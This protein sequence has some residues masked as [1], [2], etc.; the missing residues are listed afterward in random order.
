MNW[1]RGSKGNHW[2][3]CGCL[4]WNCDLIEQEL[5]PQGIDIDGHRP[6]R[7]RC[8]WWWSSLSR[9]SRS[10]KHAF[11]EGSPG[12]QVARR[13]GVI[14]A[15]LRAPHSAVKQIMS[16]AAT[17][18]ERSAVT[19]RL[20]CGIN[21]VSSCKITALWQQQLQLF[22]AC[23]ASKYI[24]HTP[25]GTHCPPA[26]WTFPRSAHPESKEERDYRLHL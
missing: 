4:E 24:T 15:M 12:S 8:R 14:I 20:P 25:L 5:W 17:H 19:L 7:C 21:S 16:Q 22:A 3:G 6:R 1:C 10:R 18:R 2:W 23:A 26:R 9:C 11:L 13:T